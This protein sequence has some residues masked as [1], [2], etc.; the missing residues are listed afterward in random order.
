MKSWRDCVALALF[1]GTVAAL[2]FVVGMVACRHNTL[3]YRLFCRAKNAATVVLDRRQAALQEHQFQPSY[4]DYSGV[5]I[6]DP[7][8]TAP[9][10]TLITGYWEMFDWRPGIVLIDS[11]GTMLHEWKTDPLDMWTESPHPDDSGRKKYVHGSYLFEN[12]DILFNLEHF[13]LVRM[14]VRGEVVWKLPV[15]THHSLH[16]NENGN[17]WASGSRWVDKS[18]PEGRERLAHYHALNARICEDYAVE[19]SPDGRLLREVS[20]LGALYKSHYAHLLWQNK[21]TREFDVLHTN[22]V[23]PLPSVIADQYPLFQAGDLLIS[24]RYTH[25]VFVMDPQ[26]QNIRWLSSEFLGQHDPDFVGDG[27]IHVF[28]N[29]K[30]GSPGGKKMR[31]SRIVAVNPQSGER[32]TVYAAPDSGGFYASWGGKAQE[33]ANGNLLITET[34][35]GRVFEVNEQGET[36]WEWVAEQRTAGVVPEVMEGTR[37]DLTREQ[38]ASWE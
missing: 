8:G 16:R 32:R 27:W 7:N 30:D 37:Y 28:D 2:V 12:G 4:Y 23:E 5:R 21:R 17:F 19:V 24:C 1:I 35:R 15:R 18:T 14:N 33:L 26:T 13:G 29:G 34:P 9:G 10:L 38:V 22:D 36:V 6:H 3:P 31:D 11:A 25:S 20:I